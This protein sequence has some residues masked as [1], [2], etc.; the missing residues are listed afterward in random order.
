MNKTQ[1]PT[2]KSGI[3][4]QADAGVQK[5]GKTPG[6]SAI[7]AVNRLRSGSTV[8]RNAAEPLPQPTAV[9]R[10]DGK[11][12]RAERREANRLKVAQ[13][14]VAEIAAANL[15]PVG[16]SFVISAN[17][18][19]G[20]PAKLDRRPATNGKGKGG[21]AKRITAVATGE[22]GRPSEFTEEEGDT[23]CTWIVEGK[24]LSSYSRATGRG[25]GTI[26]KWL[27][28]RADFHARYTSAHEDRAD[29]LVDQMVEIADD[30]QH[31]DSMEAVTAARLRVD[32][33]KWIAQKMRASRYGD[34]VEVKQTGSVSINIGINSKPQKAQ[35]VIDVGSAVGTATRQLGNS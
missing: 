14:Q 23:I 8:I 16:A 33:R 26:Y 21:Q 2:V 30:A 31:A 28:E 11:P 34:K 22:I 17:D 6:E 35:D 18:E 10:K 3:A 12:T 5:H 13:V 29:T 15:P 27:R 24:S 9:K 25:I 1:D 7:T 19:Q 32:T 4:S 20:L